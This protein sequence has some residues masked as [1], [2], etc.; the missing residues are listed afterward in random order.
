MDASIIL[1]A[2][3]PQEKVLWIYAGWSVALVKYISIIWNLSK[4]DYPRH[5]MRPNIHVHPLLA[6]IKT[7]VSLAISL[8]RPQPTTSQMWQ[9]CGRRPIAVNFGKEPRNEAL[10]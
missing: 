1:T 3:Y 9:V 7:P 2:A 10:G 4:V 6:A 5:A 8:C